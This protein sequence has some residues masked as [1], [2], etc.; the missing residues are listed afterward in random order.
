MIPAD[1]QTLVSQVVDE[2]S[3]NAVRV[4]SQLENIAL[5]NTLVTWFQFDREHSQ[6]WRTQAAADFKFVAGDQWEERDK[7]LLQ[8]QGRPVVV[9]N[10]TLP[11]IKSVAG[12]EIAS[13]DDVIFYPAN[14]NDGEQVEANQTLSAANTWMSEG[15]NAE[16]EQSRSF[17][18]S[19]VCGMGWTEQR[20]DYDEA[21]DGKYMEDRLNPL[22]MYWDRDA[23]K[24]NLADAT[25]MARLRQMTL[26]QARD[27]LESQGIT[28]VADEDI[29]ASWAIQSDAMMQ[30]PRPIEER[31]KREEN[32]AQF[33]PKD[34]VRL[35]HYQWIEREVYFKVLAPQTMPDGSQAMQLQDMSPD[36]HEIIQ[37]RATRQMGGPLQSIRCRRK[38]Y[39][40]AILGANNVL[41]QVRPVASRFGFTWA[42]I[43]GEP[44]EASGTWFGL[45]SV[46]RDPQRWANKWLSQTLHILNT[47]AKGGILAEADAFKDARKAQE[48]YA[49]P[50]AITFVSEGA[51]QKGKIMP[52]P[53]AGEVGGYQGLLEFS[54]SSIRDTAG[55]N[56]ELLGLKDINQPGVLEAQRKQAGMTILATTFESLR[57]FRWYVGRNRLSF[58][59][60]FFSDGR[61]IRIREAANVYKGMRLIADKTAGNFEVVVSD[62]P[63]SPNKKDQI[64]ATFQQLMPVLQPF[65]AQNPEVALIVLEYSPVPPEVI[66]RLRDL[67]NDAQQGIQA[68]MAQQSAELDLSKKSADVKKTLAQA[69]HAEAQATREHSLAAGDLMRQARDVRKEG[70][71]PAFSGNANLMGTGQ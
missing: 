36:E 21:W 16:R 20:I 32:A 13:R 26:A 22:E 1:D 27:W 56:L 44:D 10:R 31:R 2:T 66:D 40:Q 8:Q 19:V 12:I 15:C 67:L 30:E 50:D 63:S 18:D 68:K 57:T 5:F 28:D 65:M 55:I 37:A 25:R 51:I 53:G 43:T 46:V 9:F 6:K 4:P 49:R 33:D 42:C 59:Q 11:M 45:V 41:G 54:I 34:T 7:Q 38:V 60:D 29:D 39:K 47:T 71:V 48:T 17:R 58:I 14:P 23:R 35:V 61:L 52:K 70:I 69:D 3:A 64:W 24:D 62:A